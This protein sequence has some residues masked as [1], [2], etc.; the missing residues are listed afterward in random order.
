MGTSFLVMTMIM[1]TVYMGLNE[2]L[3]DS[4]KTGWFVV[5]GIVVVLLLLTGVFFAGGE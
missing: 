5:V 3:Q 2:K 1:G 4:S